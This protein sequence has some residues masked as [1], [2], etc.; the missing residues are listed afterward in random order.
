MNDW[1]GDNVIDLDLND[2][3]EWLRDWIEADE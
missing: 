2:D 1:C 3:F